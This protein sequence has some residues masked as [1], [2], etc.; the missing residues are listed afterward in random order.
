MNISEFERQLR[1]SQR[2]DGHPPQES[3]WLKLEQELRQKKRGLVWLAV[4]ALRRW[5]AAAAVILLIGVG[6]FARFRTSVPPAPELSR[7]TGIGTPAAPGADKSL[8]DA[9]TTPRAVPTRPGGIAGFRPHPRPPRR[10]EA[11]NQP[12]SSLLPAADTVIV[13]A[14]LPEPVTPGEAPPAVPS[15]WPQTSGERIGITDDEPSPAARKLY[16]GISAQYGRSDFSSGQYR[17]ALDARRDLS[18]RIFASVQVNA[19]AASIASRNVYQY[20]SFG[21][22]PGA[23]AVTG[24]QPATA[25]YRGN[26]FSIGLSPSLGVR[27]GKLL[28]LSA[29]A[30]LQK[31]LTS[32]L[33]L[34]N[35][36]DFRNQVTQ[37]TLIDDEQHVADFDFGLQSAAQLHVNPRLEVSMTYRYGLTNYFSRNLTVV[38]NSYLSAGLSY[39][40]NRR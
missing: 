28:S 25:H 27:A 37:Q 2:S 34:S 10:D 9:P 17:L 20:Q 15:W 8:Y 30:D 4:P 18:D 40:L 22:T 32:R 19:S 24:T 26:V 33:N 14:S 1:E 39:R 23:D 35:K 6:Y 21:Y 31:L 3:A 7:K 29:G 16:F 11:G 38:R 12:P 36:D 5:P 13:A